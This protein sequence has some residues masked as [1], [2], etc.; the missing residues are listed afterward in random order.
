MLHFWAPKVLMSVPALQ[1]NSKTTKKTPQI[2]LAQLE[3]QQGR[4]PKF[5]H[6]RQTPK[7]AALLL[8]I[9]KQNQ[10]EINRWFLQWEAENSP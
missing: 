2:Q 7:Q 1:A 9:H 3:S 5:A 6:R 10:S 4:D 8:T